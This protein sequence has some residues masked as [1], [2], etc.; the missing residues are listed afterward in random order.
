MRT[1]YTRCRR[2]SW[3][4]SQVLHASSAFLKRTQRKMRDVLSVARYWFAGR[5]VTGLASQGRQD[6]FCRM[7]SLGFKCLGVLGLEQL[8]GFVQGLI[9]FGRGVLIQVVVLILADLH[10]GGNRLI[11]DLLSVG[12]FV[13]GYRQEERRA[14][15]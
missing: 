4:N 9:R 1:A 2:L 14:I 13:L 12:T 6:R 8:Q 15:G 7:G 3:N 5:V 10:V 11:L